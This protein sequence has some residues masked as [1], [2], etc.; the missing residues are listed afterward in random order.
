MTLTKMQI[1]TQTERKLPIITAASETS[2]TTSK[3]VFVTNNVRRAVY[4]CY[5][6]C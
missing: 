1:D 5:V 2:E 4:K 3:F 6:L